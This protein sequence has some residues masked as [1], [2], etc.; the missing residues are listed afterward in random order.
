MDFAR[1]SEP[2]MMRPC[3]LRR[4]P[5]VLS[6]DTRPFRTMVDFRPRRQAF[7]PFG[8]GGAE[9]R[10]RTERGQPLMNGDRMTERSE[11]RPDGII[12]ALDGPAGSGKSSTAKAL[13]ARL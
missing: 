6:F 13:A 3:H 4:T 10:R 5:A 7:R 12:I 8:G 11:H 2:R 9:R 1:P